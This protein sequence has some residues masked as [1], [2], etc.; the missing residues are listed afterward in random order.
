MGKK[1]TAQFA[2]CLRSVLCAAAAAAVGGRRSA[3]RGSALSRSLHG[4]G[5][6]TLC[7][8]MAA[9]P[10]QFAYIVIPVESLQ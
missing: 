6:D 1:V 7:T 10:L 9:A 4:R 5:S 2:S 8:P 3:S